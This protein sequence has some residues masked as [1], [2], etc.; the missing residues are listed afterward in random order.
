MR[1][2]RALTA[3]T[4]AAALSLSGGALAVGAERDTQPLVALT[5]DGQLLS[6][7]ASAANRAT[8]VTITGLPA[9]ES[10]IGI[11]VRP[12]TG[13]LVGLSDD[14]RLY[15]IGSDGTATPLS[16]L[17]VALVGDA[18]GIDFNPTVDRLRIVTDAEQN[19]RV[20][21]DTGVAIVDG[22]LAYAA[23][24]VNAGAN[25]T[26][27][28]AAYTNN[29]DDNLQGAAMPTGTQLFDIDSGLD[30]LVLQDPPN[31]GGLKTIGSLGLDTGDLTG[32]DIAS[33]LV[34][35]RA[36]SNTAY[37]SVDGPGGSQ[38]LVSIDLATGAAKRLAPFTGRASVIDIAALPSS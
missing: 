22:T 36:V 2:S 8:A 13:Q 27:V 23:D 7:T 17:S 37:A 29:D 31:A 24:D 32:F 18:V 10:L 33:V 26:I 15:T 14:S 20:N 25:P 12:R 16:T 1:L 11:D 35:G 9:G 3:A 28:G 6:F 30:T 5:A 4:A 34:A 21:V 38:H 19:L